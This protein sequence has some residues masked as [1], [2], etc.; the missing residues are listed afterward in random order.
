MG[1]DPVRIIDEVR[2]NFHMTD[3][4]DCGPTAALEKPSK[5]GRMML[6]RHEKC[7]KSDNKYDSYSDEEN[8]YD[9]SDDDS[10]PSLCS[11][12]DPDDMDQQEVDALKLQL[13]YSKIED[14]DPIPQ[15]ETE[16]G[17]TDHEELKKALKAL[18]DDAQINGA[19]IK[20]V[21]TLRE[22]LI[23]YHNAFRLC[24][25]HDPPAEVRSLKIVL[26]LDA[27]PK[28]IP[29]R[30][31]APPQAQFLAAKMADMERLGLVKKNLSSKWASPPLIQPKAGPEKF[32]FT[33][34][35]RY[36]NSQA[37]QVSWPMPNME[38]EL[39]S[40]AG[41]KY[42]AT[43][44]LMQGYWQLP[45]H[46]D[47]QECQSII[48]PD[49]VYTP[50]RVHHGTT[51]AMVH[52][53][54]IMEDLMHDIIHSFIIWIDD[55]MIHVVDEEKLLE[56]LEYFSRNAYSAAFSSM[57]PSVTSMVPKFATADAS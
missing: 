46:E 6:L 15:D 25:G 40:L 19:S 51:N 56:V 41:S 14:D 53:Q 27:K 32:C 35:L 42:F 38:D 12:S 26:K 20:F 43:L 3:F 8:E 45:L 50:T 24:L 28:R 44:D 9:A 55:N 36:P 57:L 29:A 48:T 47:S 10:L 30:K 11:D 31:Y 22:L 7:E 13:M 2:E 39:T 49:G 16:V 21:T 18:A 37:Q 5:M 34:D 17:D 1:L 23:T 54:S 52:M 4:S 33:L